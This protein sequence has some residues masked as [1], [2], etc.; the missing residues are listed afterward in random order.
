MLSNQY[1]IVTRI[2]L[3]CAQNRRNQNFSWGHGR[4]RKEHNT[5]LSVHG[6]SVHVGTVVSL[7][8]TAAPFYVA[9]QLAEGYHI[10]RLES[11]SFDLLRPRQ[12][13]PQ[14]AEK[15]QK[16]CNLISAAAFTPSENGSLVSRASNSSSDA[17]F[18]KDSEENGSGWQYFTSL[19]GC[20]L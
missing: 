1:L 18:G 3:Q 20:H 9:E 7:D 19:Y 14:L 4:V 5:V 11:P 10:C 15:L 12:P 16:A 17:V 2:V 13:A 8:F 6:R